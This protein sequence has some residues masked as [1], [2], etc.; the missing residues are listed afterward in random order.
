M[1]L[2]LM[3]SGCNI[4]PVIIDLTILCTSE[5]PKIEMLALTGKAVEGEVLNAM[6]IMPKSDIQNK[7]WT[8]YKK[9]VRY[10]WYIEFISASHFIC[11]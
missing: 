9:D 11:N 3:M 8:K 2:C 1:L 6:E 10:Q 5:V 4:V 7:I